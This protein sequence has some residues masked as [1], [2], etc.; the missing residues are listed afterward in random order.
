MGYPALSC[1]LRAGLILASSMGKNWL[2]HTGS[3]VVCSGPES[4]SSLLQTSGHVACLCSVTLGFTRADHLPSPS[5]AAPSFHSMVAAGQAEMWSWLS[6]PYYF[7]PLICS[8]FL[9]CRGWSHMSLRSASLLALCACQGFCEP[10]WSPPT[11]VGDALN[12]SEMKV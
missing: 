10:H 7:Q 9:V 4:G 6:L 5:S 8:G 12:L 3:L 2:S 1:E 11:G